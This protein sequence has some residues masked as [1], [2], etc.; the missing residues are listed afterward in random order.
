MQSLYKVE[1]D[2]KEGNLTAAQRKELRLERSLPLTNAFG[3]WMSDELKN[4]NIPPREA[5][6]KALSYSYKR[7][8]RL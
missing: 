5:M 3:K 2:A 7:W 4:S 8:G 6:G 1:A